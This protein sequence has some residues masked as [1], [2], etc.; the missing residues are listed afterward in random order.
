MVVDTVQS[1]CPHDG[2]FC[3]LPLR[4][5]A[6]PGGQTRLLLISLVFV[7]PQVVGSLFNIW[8][9]LLHIEPLL[10]KSQLARFQTGILWVNGILYPL[11]L[12]VGFR[13]LWSLHPILTEVCAGRAVS[14]ARLEW[15][16]S[17]AINLPWW[18]LGIAVAGWLSCI[19]LFLGI[20]GT[21]SEPL[22][23]RVFLH[24]PLSLLISASIAISIGFFFVELSVQRWLFPLLFVDTQPR[25]T[26][27]TFP[28]TLRGRGIMLTLSAC[29]A[30]I[31]S[32][33]LLTLSPESLQGRGEWFALTVGLLA[34][35]F[36]LAGAWAT[37]NLVLE[38]VYALRR[39]A[40]SVRSG[41]LEV[42]VDVLR[43]DEFGSLI[44]TV[45]EM[46]VELREKQ[47]LEDLFGRHV[48]REAARKLLT[49]APGAPAGVE[50]V[51]TVLFADLRGFTSRSE[52][53]SA[54]RA[55]AMLNGYFTEMVDVIEQ[56]HG[57][58]VNKFLGDGMMALFGAIDGR[59]NHADKAVEAALTMMDR[60]QQFNLDCEFLD[61]QPLEMGIGI[62][63]GT[64]IV[65]SIGSERRG[66]FTAIGSTVNLA[67]RIES[68]T[69][70]VRAPVLISL[71][72][73][74]AMSQTL[75]EKLGARLR[76]LPPALIR[77][78]ESPVTL[79]A[80]DPV[81]ARGTWAT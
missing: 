32:L 30:P 56:V 67:S 50:Q 79:Y 17:R 51:L 55:V 74:N 16:R 34:I 72:T 26:V 65:G 57:G 75:L 40:E 18:G 4:S 54:S 37:S 73:R 35:G 9:N 38:P 39:V 44:G 19:P 59:G 15:A 22:D 27:G 28:L 20:L 29:V 43:A 80:L 68:H 70:Q 69:K 71:A 1:E 41:D 81:P 3:L 14:C 31:G 33:L 5:Q 52:R 13:V 64:A 63:T 62:C 12:A 7:G 24:L 66:E 77:G 76:E 61:G 53:I 46:I 23:S 21:S 49:Q 60:L 48:G 11:A 36:G 47:K 58:M 45:N 6:S 8:Y 42:R 2:E 25:D 78:I 10:S